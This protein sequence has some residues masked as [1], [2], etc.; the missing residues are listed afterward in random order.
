LGVSPISPSCLLTLPDCPLKS[1]VAKYFLSFLFRGPFWPPLFLIPFVTIPSYDL[2]PP[3]VHRRWL[4][5]PSSFPKKPV[6]PCLSSFPKV[7]AH[8][9][10]CPSFPSA[11]A[12]LVFSFFSP[13]V[14][15][16]SRCT[17]KPE[18][19][20]FFCLSLVSQTLVFLPHVLRRRCRSPCPSCWLPPFPFFLLTVL[21]FFASFFFPLVKKD[22][23][24]GYPPWL[25]FTF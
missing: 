11:C 24:V 18:V 9:P 1:N 13:S 3:F 2:A 14:V 16:F 12:T 17:P 19:C 25:S 7:L 6:Q 20:P 22:M 8:L 21:S 15:F 23:G 10:P 4:P 5:F